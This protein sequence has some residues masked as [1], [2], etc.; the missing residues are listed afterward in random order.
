MKTG[1]TWIDRILRNSRLAKEYKAKYLKKKRAFRKE[2]F[3]YINELR[4]L[5]RF[6][7]EY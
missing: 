5:K 2:Y 3:Q 1:I 4:V 7:N 6:K